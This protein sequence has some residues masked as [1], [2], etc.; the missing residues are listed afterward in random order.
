MAEWSEHGQ[1]ASRGD[2]GARF[3]GRNTFPL[4]FALLI[5]AHWGLT[6]YFERPEVVFSDIPNSWLD[7]DTHIEQAWTV[8]EALDRYGKSWAYEPKLLAGY[9]TGTLFDSD[10]KAW[11]L[12]T[13][14][15]SKLGLS[16][17]LAF[18]LFIVLA[19][20]AVPWVVFFAA[21][22]FGLKKW[23]ALLAAAMGILLWC[24]DVYPRWCWWVGMTAYAM[25]SYFFL[26]PLSLFYRFLKSFKWLHLALAALFMSIGHL[27]HPL[28]FVML[29][30]P[31]LSLY[32]RAFKK[33]SLPKHLGI[34][35]VAMVVLAANSY[36]LVVTFRFI[37]LVTAP[38]TGIYGQGTITFFLTDYLGLLKEPLASGVLGNRTGF[39][40]VFL[41]AA[42]ICIVFWRKESD[43][44]FWP[45]AAAIGAMLAVA[46][47]GGQLGVLTYIQPYRHVLPAMYLSIIPAAAFSHKVSSGKALQSLPRVTYAI[48]GLVLLIAGQNLAR[49]MLYFFVDS[50]PRPTLKQE[51][52]VE[53]QQVNPKVPLVTDWHMS[54]R[55]EP[56]YKD[57]DAMVEWVND[58]DDGEGRIL[59][60]WWI[61]GEHLAWR[62]D[63]HI[64]GGFLDRGVMHSSS[65]LFYRY[66]SRKVGKKE[67]KKY[68]EDYAVKWVILSRP[69]IKLEKYSDLLKPVANL[70]PIHRIYKTKTPV[71]FF[72]EGSGRVEASLNRIEVKETD[73]SRDVVLRFHW[74]DTLICAEGCSIKQDPVKR[75]P[76]GFIRVLAPHPADFTIE[77]GY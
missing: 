60:E 37:H 40:F 62:T 73:P 70:F 10:N 66:A 30:V 41:S 14:A 33:L 3:L 67:V 19:H 38:E 63:S 46:Y 75:D 4:A 20:L 11:E 31:M 34:I 65:S 74:F 39:R 48:G 53:L 61:L 7:Y 12:W 43:D 59:V 24:F 56:V 26:L 51:D 28:T 6:F 42:I 64:L 45:F 25:A 49:D 71:S 27:L 5:A 21:R 9:P 54:H 50:L 44:R 8:S 16:K 68:F 72:A 36:W 29:V 47:V 2:K 35:G 58:N 15:L 22:L 17:G 18:N 52:R 32:I 55:H 57:F 13:F 1:I 77:N 76:V 69:D 23:T